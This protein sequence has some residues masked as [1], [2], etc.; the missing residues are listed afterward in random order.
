MKT[1]RVVLFLI[2]CF[3][4]IATAL[5]AMAC[6]DLSSKHTVIFNV[7]YDTEWVPYA[8]IRTTGATILKFPDDP[9]KE[10]YV[11]AGW[12]KDA[13]C[14]REGHEY[15][16]EN[17]EL[18]DDVN[19]Y[20]KFVPASSIANP[21]TITFETN[22][23]SAVEAQ[24]INFGGKL[25]PDK[26]ETTRPGFG[27]EGWY[28]EAECKNQWNVKYDRVWKS[29]TLYAKW[30]STGYILTYELDGGTNH[31]KNPG[32][33][34]FE[35]GLTLFDPT[36]LGYSFL[37]WYLDDEFTIP[38]N[39]ETLYDDNLTIY[40][41]W[42]DPVVYHIV[43]ELGT[44]E[45]LKEGGVMPT[46]YTVLDNPLDFPDVERTGYD[47]IG[48]IIDEG[49]GEL[50]DNTKTYAQDFNLKSSMTEHK[51][52]ITYELNGGTNNVDNRLYVT[53][54]QNTVV[55]SNPAKKGYDFA[56]WYSDSGFNTSFAS[57]TA[58][59][60]DITLYAKW[61]LATYTITYHVD[62]S[63]TCSNT[64]S[65]YNINNN[66]LSL[67]TPT[68]SDLYF[69]G[70]YLDSS[71]I[72][73]FDSTHI[74]AENLDLYP[75]FV[76]NE[77]LLPEHYYKCASSD[78]LYLSNT[79]VRS[80]SKNVCIPMS[81]NKPVKSIVFNGNSVASSSYI[82]S[83][84][85]D[86][87]VIAN[88]VFNQKDTYN[89]YYVVQGDK[90]ELVVTFNDDT[91]RK[92]YVSLVGMIF[93][94]YSVS[95]FEKGV[96][97]QLEV[98]I[99]GVTVSASNINN[100]SIDGYVVTYSLNTSAHMIT[101]SS[102]VL[103]DMAIGSHL[104]EVT[105]Y[106]DSQMVDFYITNDTEFA[107]YNVTVDIDSDPGKVWILWDEDSDVAT[108]KVMIDST[109]Y[110][111]ASYP[112]LFDGNRFNATD[113]LTSSGQ[114]YR[115][116]A[117][118]SEA[119]YPSSTYTFK[120]NM[121][122][123]AITNYLENTVSVYGKS[124]NMY[125]SSWEE[126]YDILFYTAIKSDELDPYGGGYDDYGV[127]YL[128]LDFDL[129]KTEQIDWTYSR[130][131]SITAENR[132][133]SNGDFVT[134]LIFETLS[135]MPEALPSSVLRLS[136][137]DGPVANQ[138]YK[139][140][141]K[142][143]G[144]VTSDINRTL[145]N[146]ENG[147][148]KDQ[149]YY[150]ELFGTNN[151]DYTTFPIETNNNGNA[152]VNSSVELYLALEHGYNPVIKSGNAEL[153]AL[154]NTMK[155]VLKSVVDENMTDYQKVAAIYQWL[156]AE[157]LYDHAAANDSIALQNA[158]AAYA[159]NDTSAAAVAARQAYY[160]T[161]GWSCFYM[162]G[163]FNNHLAVCNGIASAY[164]A[165]CNMLGIKC[166]KLTGTAT[167]DEDNVQQH[168]WNK[169][170]IGGKWY[171]SDATWGSTAVDN[172]EVLTYQYLFMTEETAVKT[173]KHI[174]KPTP[175]GVTYADDMNINIYKVLKYTSSATKYDFTISN[176]EDF[177]RLYN[178]AISKLGTPDS[179][180]IVV[181][182]AQSTNSTT[183]YNYANALKYTSYYHVYTLK[184][185]NNIAI[186]IR[187]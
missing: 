159:S 148:W 42:S 173:Y 151:Y 61:T 66:P 43:Y 90:Y 23:G 65:S 131:S 121:T 169:V 26:I 36:R 123:S 63:T 85:E 116:I 163:V 110:T 130:Y 9:T 141:F 129:S 52:Y 168:A 181:I 118:V 6:S 97:T 37:G 55:L 152:T 72:E 51:Y 7:Q 28:L 39:S 109:E 68:K 19:Y 112:G 117:T 122:S 184:N 11:F 16:Y 21:Y 138:T 179:G 107:P 8:S 54:S 3:I 102:S 12:Y 101:V 49:T 89:N 92:Y 135:N 186:M 24:E 73:M 45:A 2:V 27:F 139:L 144:S 84:E 124:M 60:D 69:G 64:P 79:E 57:G 98:V 158:A 149:E 104:L 31:P 111:Q 99:T 133:L 176:Q 120:Y 134:A 50:F 22:K 126:L 132:V 76:S 177:D 41:K 83:T 30:Y 62:G 4:V 78:A 165:M 170:Y 164:S 71:L 166:I 143:L 115:V 1:K 128:C 75:K 103:N 56:G 140:G 175:Y 153:A 87:L 100:V 88:A 80:N 156:A 95:T 105:T 162:E 67:P 146:T 18:T 171:V 58:I 14:T 145:E 96:S 59:D 178:Y 113:K 108:M 35:D 17:E 147:A 157:V 81:N 29:R 160:D 180:Q 15:D 34:K 185:R 154:Y 183:I 114:T 33:Y 127:L 91:T 94:F 47:F 142:Y 93:T 172:Y 182:E 125:I 70:W 161:F 48:W 150:P 44:G 25:D 167:D 119:N 38:F 74:Y 106:N 46:E 32:I 53:Y 187:R 40:A 155:T 20:A 5:G 86:I 136:Q 174:A 77:M 137:N 10:G 82:Y 13:S